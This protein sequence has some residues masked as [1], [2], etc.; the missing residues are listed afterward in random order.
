MYKDKYFTAIVLASGKGKRMNTDMPKQFMNINGYPMLYYSL[1]A[2]EDSLVDSIVLVTSADD[3]GYCKKEIVDSYNLTKVH[4]IVE[5]GVERYHSTAAGLK[6]CNEETDY[7]MI[8]DCARP[9]LTPD[10]ISSS[11]ESVIANGACTVAVKVTDTICKT[12]DGGVIIEIPNRNYLWSVQTPQSFVFEEI[13]RAH[14]VLADTEPKMT[15]EEKTSITDDVWVWKKFI[16]KDVWIVEGSYE[17]VKVTNPA[18]VSKVEEYLNHI[19]Y[20]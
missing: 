17:N 16:T 7:V 6:V 19:S 14:E 1:K 10:I 5:G 12:S 13:K 3:I 20:K 11:M 15:I 8:H 4:A 18:D 9:C 2:F